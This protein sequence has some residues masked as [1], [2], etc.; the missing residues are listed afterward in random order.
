MQRKCVRGGLLGLAFL[1]WSWLLKAFGVITG[2]DADF[3]KIA[4]TDGGEDGGIVLLIVWI[5]HTVRERCMEYK[6]LR[7]SRSR[8]SQFA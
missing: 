3:A 8:S 5:L 4:G 2:G 7:R 6:M 1:W